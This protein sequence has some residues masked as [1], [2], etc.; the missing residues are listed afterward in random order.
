MSMQCV[1]LYKYAPIKYVAETL[2]NN[3]IYLNDGRNFND[4]FEITVADN[5]NKEIRR[6]EG[7]HILSLTNSYRKKLMWSH[8]TESHQ[9]VCLTVKVPRN[10]VYPICYSSRRVYEDSNV[11]EIIASSQRKLKNYH[12]KNNISKDYS[13][14]SRDK[15][16]AYIKDKKWM[17]EN[18][19]RIVFDRDDE[20]YLISEDNNWFM[21][22]KVTNVYLGVNFDK[23]QPE[24]KDEIMNACKRNKIKVAQMI[25]SDSDYSINVKR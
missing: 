9:G 19:Y 24:I 10:L 8:Y 15:K 13:S 20:R 11:A 14:L 4:P 21:P 3:R 18:E 25:L 23:N 7:L 6:L 12:T 5:H 22:V 17:Y 16:I 2:N 1:I